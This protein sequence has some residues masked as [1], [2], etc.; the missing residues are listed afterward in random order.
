MGK[1]K[2]DTRVNKLAQVTIFNKFGRF[3]QKK[4]NLLYYL[5]NR[6]HNQIKKAQVKL[7][8]LYHLGQLLT[9]VTFCIQK[10]INN[11]NKTILIFSDSTLLYSR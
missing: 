9:Q 8:T 3:L 2:I 6:L 7:I 10:H 11:E 5:K 4:L 1:L